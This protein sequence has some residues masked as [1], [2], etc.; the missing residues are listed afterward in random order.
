MRPRVIVFDNEPIRICRYRSSYDN[1]P[2]YAISIL[3]YEKY[4]RRF[5]VAVGVDLRKELELT[6]CQMRGI[7]SN[8]RWLS[9]YTEKTSSAG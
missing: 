7:E 4:V 5:S 6:L 9:E 3:N 1:R 8:L 2:M